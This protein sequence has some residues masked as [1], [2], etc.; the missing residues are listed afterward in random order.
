MYTYMCT[1]VLS[2]LILFYCLLSNCFIYLYSHPSTAISMATGFTD[3][4]ESIASIVLLRM[5]LCRA[6]GDF[7]NDSL[8][9]ITR[10]TFVALPLYSCPRSLFN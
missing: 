6:S 5:S 9:S 7:E 8:F 1:V 2:L 4:V 10:Q 3:V